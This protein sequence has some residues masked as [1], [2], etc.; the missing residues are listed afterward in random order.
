MKRLITKY[1]FWGALLILCPSIHAE[2]AIKLNALYAC[3]G[4]VNPAVEIGVHPQVTAQ[5]EAVGSFYQSITLK[6]TK[7]QNVP[8]LFGIGFV[9]AHWFPIPKQGAFNGF[10]WG[11]SL[12][13][14]MFKLQKWNYW[15]TD[16]YQWG[17]ALFLGAVVGYQWQVKQ[18][19]FDL[20]LGGG[21]EHSIYE[22]YAPFNDSSERAKDGVNYSRYELHEFP[23]KYNMSAEWMPFKGGL[24]I[25]YRF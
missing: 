12:G 22:G 18:W 2:T 7:I 23:G 9:E 8:L 13:W 17:S 21:W 10:Y 16:R 19:T 6:N 15:G 5:L 1:L 14:G 4:I 3:G 11:P 24:M 20:F 25:G